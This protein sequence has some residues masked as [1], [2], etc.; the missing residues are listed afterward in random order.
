MMF[1]TIFWELIFQSTD[2]FQR[3]NLKED[4]HI[5]IFIIFLHFRSLV[6]K[7]GRLAISLRIVPIEILVTGLLKILVM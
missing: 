1:Q 6:K 7:N 5:T 2:I 3:G 4:L